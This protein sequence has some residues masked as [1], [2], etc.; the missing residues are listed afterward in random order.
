[1]K[2]ILMI[3]DDRWLSESYRKILR[4]YEVEIVRDGYDAMEQINKTNYDVV[5]AD[6]M[7]E[8][9]TIVEFLHELQS[10]G[11][12]QNLP[13]IL[14]TQLAGKISSLD[15]QEYGVK[16]VLDKAQLTPQTLRNSVMEVLS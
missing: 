1:M 16:K 10:Y 15:M 3:E 13:V 9:G 14:C 12:T 6:V 8:W 7:I 4:E 2:R 11:D 5:I